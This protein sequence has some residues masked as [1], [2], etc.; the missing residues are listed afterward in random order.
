MKN[1]VRIS[2]SQ[3]SLLQVA[4]ERYEHSQ[5][6]FALSVYLVI[7]A[8]TK[9]LDDNPVLNLINAHAEQSMMLA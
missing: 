6:I 9:F 3:T 4:K 5:F 1:E 7:K 8:N 2:V